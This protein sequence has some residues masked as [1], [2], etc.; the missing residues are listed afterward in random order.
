[1]E[2]IKSKLKKGQMV[3]VYELPLTSEKLEG[4][5]VLIRNCKLY[6]QHL[7]QWLVRFVGDSDQEIV[8]RFTDEKNLIV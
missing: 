7:E 8:E 6:F 5:A 4:K 1:M 2:S 3:N